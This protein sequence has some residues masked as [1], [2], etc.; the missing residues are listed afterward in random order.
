MGTIEKENDTALGK[1]GDFM[2][3]L[4]VAVNAK[5]IHSNLAVYSLRV[6]A[7]K[8]AENIKIAELTINHSE[9]DILKK[10]YQEN[11][12]VV[13]FSCYIWNIHIIKRITRELKKI[14]KDV[15]IWYGGPEVSYD[16]DK[17]LIENNEL[18]GI[19]IGEGEQTFL[20]LV[21]YYVEGRNKLELIS[22]LAYKES[23]CNNIEEVSLS[24]KFTVTPDRQP[25]SL[26]LLPLPYENI[27]DFENKI[28]YYESSRGCPFSCSYCLSSIDKKVRLKSSEIVTKELKLFLNKKVSQVK[29]VDRT[30]NC[31]KKHAM[32]IWRFI[33]ENDNG[34][35][36]FHF[37]ISADLLSE[38]EIAFLATLRPGQVQF[39]IG[40][41][42]TNPDTINAIHRKMDFDKLSH[43]VTQI[44]EAKNIHQHLDLIAGLP[45][46]GYYS[47]ERSFNDVYRL[48]PDQLQL[49]FLKI[50]KGSLMEAESSD[51]GI[52]YRS[53]P[54][55]EVLYTKW[56]NYEETL[57]IKGICEMV[58]IYYNSAQFTYSIN[59]LEHFFESPMKLYE[60][61][62]HYYEDSEY[63]AMAH[64]RIRRY[65]ILLDFFT[66][67]ISTGFVE[68]DKQEQIELFK[69]LLIMDIYLRENM[70]TRPN[71]AP[72]KSLQQNH[73]KICETY[74]LN[75]KSVHIEQFAF[76]LLAASQEGKLI[77]KDTIL[78]FDYSN[79]DPL[80]KAVSVTT[81]S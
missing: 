33:K 50:L 21:Q 54:P 19:M 53:T 22:G 26:D 28:L 41:Q 17:C 2:K 18:D 76:D 10:I 1:N 57:R 35:T 8:Y 71:F 5:Y 4:L 37:E 75:H 6:F 63:A 58:E 12:D 20:E 9:E 39:E 65:E 69:E 43:N 48:K 68:E 74:H 62:N 42:S 30:F 77:K 14:Q 70:K 56:L 13:A 60:T 67:M 52:T 11:A 79:K 36:N 38:E 47:F 44:K 31:N 78:L 23:A 27:E 3:I 72:T 16:I 15:K 32:D 66:Q 29:F 80:S 34:I 46:E 73:R 55:Y 7:G 81:F 59:F 40:V 51:Y 64:S 24:K 49:G 45:L 25:I 61:L